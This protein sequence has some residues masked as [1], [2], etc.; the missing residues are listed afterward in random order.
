[1]FAILIVLSLVLAGV[2]W[3]LRDSA[4][5]GGTI[6]LGLGIGI[7]G[8]SLLY[9]VFVVLL[10]MFEAVRSLKDTGEKLDNSTEM[11]TRQN[12]LLLQISQGMRLSDTAKEIVFRDDEQME[13]GEAALN[14]LHQHDFEDA[15]AMIAAMAEQPKYRELATR[16]KRMA[17]KYRSA[18]EEG[19]INQVVAHIEELFEQYLWAQAT[20]QIENFIKTFPHSDKAKTMPARLRERKD[21]HK[22]ELLADWDMAIRNKDTDRGL[23]IL[24]EL[25]LY[26][27]PAEALALQESAATV[28]R[29]K[30]HNLGVDFSVAVTEK[31]WRTAFELGKEIVQS[32]PNSRMAAEIRSKMDILQDRA[33]AV[34]TEGVGA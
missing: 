15:E 32:F 8:S 5:K 1:L 33:R 9:A 21:R 11:L 24:K 29:T 14:K 12:T 4:W 17:D 22:R 23:E 19:R 27:T 28:F 13:L 18:T 7:G 26:L 20:V 34:T 25:D 6:L 10:L 3:G 31:N 30:L 2:G 16:L